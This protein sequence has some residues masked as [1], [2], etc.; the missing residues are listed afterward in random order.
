MGVVFMSVG[1]IS[2]DV[3]K[4]DDTTMSLKIRNCRQYQMQLTDLQ[5]DSRLDVNFELTSLS[6]FLDALTHEVTRLNSTSVTCTPNLSTHER[7]LSCRL[8]R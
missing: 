4:A 8:Y 7:F 6:R 2:T 1:K 3:Y 5:S